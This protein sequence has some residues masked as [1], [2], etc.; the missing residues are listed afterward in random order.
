MHAQM[1]LWPVLKD[2][3]FSLVRQRCQLRIAFLGSQGKQLLCIRRYRIIC[4]IGI[5][6]LKFEKNITPTACKNQS[7]L[8]QRDMPVSLNL[9]EETLHSYEGS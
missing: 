8:C 9:Q 2:F 4:G 5:S 1:I 7:C 3:K 6:T